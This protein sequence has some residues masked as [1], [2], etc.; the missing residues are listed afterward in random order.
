MLKLLNTLKVLAVQ[1][2]GSSDKA[3]KNAIVRIR[4]SIVQLV[5]MLIR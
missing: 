5:T 2:K 1:Y 4:A 3:Y